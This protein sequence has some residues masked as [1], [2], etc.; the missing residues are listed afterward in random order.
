MSNKNP[1]LYV[2]IPISC[3]CREAQ[4]IEA[5]REEKSISTTDDREE[6]S[7]P[8]TT[9]TQAQPNVPSPVA[10]AHE[11]LSAAAK[12]PPSTTHQP[13]NN[14]DASLDNSNP[15]EEPHPTTTQE[16]QASP[17]SD[18]TTTSTQTREDG[19]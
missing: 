11:V 2:G 3:T 10:G 6:K 15:T 9:T 18:F 8:M 5:S 14:Q 1:F 19:V 12:E 17:A 13:P 7:I 16:A 4:P